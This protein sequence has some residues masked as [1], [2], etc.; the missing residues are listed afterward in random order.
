MFTS[1]DNGHSDSPVTNTT[2]FENR[3]TEADIKAGHGG[4]NGNVRSTVGE[5]NNDL[6]DIKKTS[7]LQI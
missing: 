5:E 4:P 7:M 6:A 1:P 3:R 2:N